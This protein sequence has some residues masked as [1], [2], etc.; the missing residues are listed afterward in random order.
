MKF[1][2]D[3]KGAKRHRASGSSDIFMVLY[4]MR[5]FPYEATD[6]HSGTVR[7]NRLANISLSQETQESVALCF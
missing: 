6:T 2:L 7:E 1:Y 5:Y 4:Q 3:I